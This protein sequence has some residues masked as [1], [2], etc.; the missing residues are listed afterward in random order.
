MSPSEILAGPPPRPV[1]LPTLRGAPRPQMRTLEATVELVPDQARQAADNEAAV[2]GA[3]EK[4]RRRADLDHGPPELP[5]RDQTKSFDL[6]N[7]LTGAQIGGKQATAGSERRSDL[8]SAFELLERTLV[9]QH[10]RRNDEM[11]DERA[12][13]MLHLRA[14]LTRSHRQRSALSPD[15]LE[16]SVSSTVSSMSGATYSRAAG[17]VAPTGKRAHPNMPSIQFSRRSSPAIVP[18][19]ETLP[20]VFMTPSGRAVGAARNAPASARITASESNIGTE[21]RIAATTAAATIRERSSTPR[22]RAQDADRTYEGWA[23]DW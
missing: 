9:N 20:P 15:K 11:E 17:I 10:A 13:H 23:S 22:H 3:G 14:E 16:P 12:A 7:L 8:D 2:T 5:R 1:S 19:V 4:V 21:R 18:D 6:P